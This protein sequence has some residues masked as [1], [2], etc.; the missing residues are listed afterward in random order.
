MSAAEKLVHGLAGE[1]KRW[2]ENVKYLSTNIK[3]IIGDALHAAAFISYIDI[4][5]WVMEINLVARS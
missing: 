1:N 3:S 4:K 5:K 2:N